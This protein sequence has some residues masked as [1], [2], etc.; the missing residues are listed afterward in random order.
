[1]TAYADMSNIIQSMQLNAYDIIIK[2]FDAD[3]FIMAVKH[4]LDNKR[5]D[6]KETININ[7]NLY[8]LSS[9][10]SLIGNSPIIYDLYKYDKVIIR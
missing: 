10:T 1:M 5:I 4:A 8:K 2:P 6:N 7:E 3:R 9:G